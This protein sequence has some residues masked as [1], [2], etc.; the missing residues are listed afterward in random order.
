MSM[1]QIASDLS[2]VSIAEAAGVSAKYDK[3]NVAKAIAANFFIG[4]SL[5]AGLF[6]FFAAGRG[7]RAKRQSDWTLG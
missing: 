5:Y 4:V 6:D 2:T 1:E 3:P 7:Q